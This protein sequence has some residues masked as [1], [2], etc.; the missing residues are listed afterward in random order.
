MKSLTKE[1][2]ESYKNA[3]ICN[4]CEENFENKYLKSKKILKFEITVIIQEN[5]EVL[6]SICWNKVFLKKFL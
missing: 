4:I 5:I 3:K 6:N 2:Q 1:H